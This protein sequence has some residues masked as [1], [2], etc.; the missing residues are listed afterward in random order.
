MNKR[1]DGGLAV[2]AAELLSFKL[3]TG[4]CLLGLE[5]EC[6]CRCQGRWHNDLAGAEVIIPASLT[7]AD[8]LSAAGVLTSPRSSRPA[9]ARRGKQR[10]PVTPER[11]RA[12]YAADIA[13]GRMPSKRQIKRDW[14]VGYATAS[15]LHG[16]LT[17]AMAAT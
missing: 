12:F 9:R 1:D 3:C 14:P 7:L 13:S 2:T 17:A 5:G 6:Q 16:H 11:V 10:G 15:D 8:A 4:Q